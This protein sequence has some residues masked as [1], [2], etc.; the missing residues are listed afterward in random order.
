M[1]KIL[2]ENNAIKYQNAFENWHTTILEGNNDLSFII[3][4][5]PI[6]DIAQKICNWTKTH[7]QSVRRFKLFLEQ[8]YKNNNPRSDA[9]QNAIK[10]QGKFIELKIHIKNYITQNSMDGVEKWR[11]NEIIKILDEII[12][13]T[14]QNT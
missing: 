4:T 7:I 10:R 6:T 13:S 5:F 11:L 2:N 9:F 12:K 14:N 1:E 8:Q 3:D